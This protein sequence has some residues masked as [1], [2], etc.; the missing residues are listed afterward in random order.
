MIN[1]RL[2]NTI[3]LTLQF[4]TQILLKVFNLLTNSQLSLRNVF[5]HSNGQFRTVSKEMKKIKNRH[6][7]TNS[8]C[9]GNWF[10]G[11]GKMAFFGPNL[12]INGANA[13]PHFGSHRNAGL[14]VG[15]FARVNASFPNF[16]VFHRSQ[17]QQGK[18]SFV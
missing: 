13:D 6:F 11:A 16:R 1:R 5:L 15:S 17:W 3:F 12:S 10:I 7:F 14:R 4:F 9:H 8:G 2:Q 18:I